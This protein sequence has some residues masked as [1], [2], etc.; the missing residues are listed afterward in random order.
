MSSAEEQ[1]SP[2]PPTSLSEEQIR[3]YQRDGFLVL[4]AFWGEAIIQELI[5]CIEELEKNVK[6]V[7]SPFKSQQ[8]NSA[9]DLI[10]SA[11]Q[12]VGFGAG[13]KAPI[14]QIGHCLHRMVPS[15]RKHSY[16]DEIWKLCRALDVSNPQI[17]QSKVVLKPKAHGWRVPVHSDEQFIY[18]SPLSGFGLWWALD[19]CTKD[20]GCLE[21]IAGSHKEFYMPQRFECDHKELKTG[22]NYI[23]APASKSLEKRDASRNRE[24]GRVPQIAR[25][26]G[27]A[28]PKSE[29]LE[30]VNQADHEKKKPRACSNGTLREEG[31]G[32]I[33]SKGVE[34]EN[35]TSRSTSAAGAA[36]RIA[37]TKKVAK[38]H[39]SRWETLEMEPGDV[40]ILHPYLL[41]ASNANRSD[42]SRRAFT[43]HLIDGELP[44]SSGNW[45]QPLPEKAAF[46]SFPQYCTLSVSS[47]GDSSTDRGSSTGIVLQRTNASQPQNDASASPLPPKSKR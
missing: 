45:I 3:A 44:W 47:T 8:K 25:K 22:F 23:A 26:E 5:Q 32:G 30:A 14:Q 13:G 33:D 2:T 6:R 7:K 24:G 10:D 40:V 42:K 46:D 38:L 41:H 35:S 16:C 12:V 17:V 21:V 43:I 37:W 19:R 18:T 9:R 31:G 34:K 28:K 4:K 1:P 15:F 39:K 36:K 20:N 27:E 11:H 29:S